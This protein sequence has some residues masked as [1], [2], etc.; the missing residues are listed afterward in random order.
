MNK[1]KIVLFTGVALGLG[2]LAYY[3]YKRKKKSNGE[4]VEASTVKIASTESAE[5]PNII[6]RRKRG[7]KSILKIGQP[8]PGAN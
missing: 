5:E 4:E 6:G 8:R 7:A 3:L 2:L 1:K